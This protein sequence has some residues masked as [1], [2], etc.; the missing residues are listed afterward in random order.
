M[1]SAQLPSVTLLVGYLLD[2]VGMGMVHAAHGWVK[3]TEQDPRVLMVVSCEC[4][5]WPTAWFE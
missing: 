3:G 5:N 2:Q 1:F 4:L